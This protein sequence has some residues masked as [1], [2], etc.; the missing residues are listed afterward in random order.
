[1][2]VLADVRLHPTAAAFVA[3][4]PAGSPDRYRRGLAEALKRIE[5]L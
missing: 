3:D 4:P 1:M 5:D 2:P